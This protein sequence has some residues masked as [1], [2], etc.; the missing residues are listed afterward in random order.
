MKKLLL[1]EDE[2]DLAEVIQDNLEAEG[3]N[4]QSAHDG[5][6][7]LA[8]WKTFQPD[9]VVLDVML[10]KMD[11]LQVCQMMREEGARM[12][13]LFLSAKGQPEDRVRGLA[14]GGDDYIVK[15]FHL[16]EF[17]MRVHTMLRR[18]NWAQDEEQNAWYT[19]G[20][21]QVHLQQGKSILKHG[22]TIHLTPEERKLFQYFT[23]HPDETLSRELLLD[24]LW[25][26]GVYPSTRVLERLVQELRNY[27]EP[28]PSDPRYFHRLSGIRFQFTPE[29]EAKS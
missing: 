6:A 10:P 12:P 7:G 17:L 9:L 25:S 18:Q 29:G 1:I 16:P 5:E 13:V 19:F 21:H 3:Y 28:N 2:H 14:V 22:Q 8:L 15:P 26:D 27:F 24:A 4:V 20:G 11:G 23:A